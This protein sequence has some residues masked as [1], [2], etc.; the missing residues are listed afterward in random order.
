MYAKE[1]HA[2][3]DA[4]TKHHP[5]LKEVIRSR[6]YSTIF[7]QRPLKIQK[8]LVGK[9]TLEPQRKRCA[10]ARPQ[11]QW[12]RCLQS[13]NNLTVRD[14]QTGLQR[15]LEPGERTLLQERLSTQKTMTWNAARKLL[16]LHSGELFN[17]EEGNQKQLLGNRTN[18]DLQKALGKQWEQMAQGDR[19]ALFEDLISI[20]KE[21][22]L[23]ARLSGHWKFTTQQTRDLMDMELQP[24]YASLSLKAIR[25]LLPYL[26]EGKNY[27]EA[28]QAAGYLEEKDKE[29]QS[30]DQLPP[31]PN[32]RSPV[33]QK[34]LNE[35]VKLVNRILREYGKPAVIRVELARDMKMGKKQIQEITRRNNLNRKM[36]EEAD[37]KIQSLGIT[38]SGELRIKYRLW[39]EQE[40]ICPYSG[41]GIGLERLFSNDTEVDHILPYSRTLDDSYM[42]K[43]VSLARENREKLD[44]TPYEKWSGN[45]SRYQEILG[46]VSGMKKM[47]WGK[48]LRFQQK[49]VLLDTFIARQLNETRYISREA[50]S[51]LKQLGTRVQVT[52]G[53]VT[54]SLRRS[55]DVNRI[56]AL[57]ADM[58]KNRSDH[59]H[60]AVDALVIALTGTRMYQSIAR[61]SSKERAVLGSRR[62][63]LPPPWKGFAEE[64]KEKIQ[65]ILVSHAP[66][67][68]I[69]G[70]LHE[71]TAY[72]KG[73]HEGKSVFVKRVSLPALTQAQAERIRDGKIKQLVLARMEQHG[74]N[75]KK[76]FA[77]P[78]F[79]PHSNQG[80]GK[81]QIKSVRILENLNEDSLIGI[82]EKEA[83]APYKFYVYGNN[84][85]VEII[86][87]THTG[88]REGRFVTAMEAAK[89]VRVL[90]Q[91][92]V[93]KDHGENW[94]FIMSLS[95]ND[96]VEIEENEKTKLYRIQKM[97]G[98]I[99]AINLRLHSAS[100]LDYD[101][102]MLAKT[103]NTLRVKRKVSID[104]L[105]NIKQAND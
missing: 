94:K 24:G 93:K 26:E 30:L 28:Q 31:P 96:L 48:K 57:D 95:I 68:K 39:H 70:A 66:S 33:V 4:Q 51:F 45:A 99:N 72:G 52:R 50:S 97:S 14:P 56:L 62:L 61:L 76:A 58:E 41:E 47:P 87:N 32:L 7:K 74:G 88:K 36:N 81:T 69:T 40:G 64:A 19:D 71:E 44:S 53:Q 55:W 27:Y 9:C 60:H 65:S 15:N 42:N 12:F 86:E 84:H 22:T 75:S 85:H 49:E 8:F 67:R 77:K 101:E 6:I 23:H 13:I 105:G 17:L 3:W 10:W 11:A 92:I 98:A 29:E 104:L 43:V 54:A 20:H 1:F 59:R 18:A 16:G 78:L 91:P 25:K 38:P 83:A 5:L 90:K 35:M 100:T 79:L 34:T 73:L 37:A 46:R 103:P 102:E 80:S 21:E 2:I 89:R 63:K 82:S